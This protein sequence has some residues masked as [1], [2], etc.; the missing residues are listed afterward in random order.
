MMAR[1]QEAPMQF[2]TDMAL[3]EYGGDKIRDAVRA[4]ACR[5]GLK[6]IPNFGAEVSRDENRMGFRVS[7]YADSAGWTGVGEPARG[8][9]FMESVPN[10]FR[11]T[12]SGLW[13]VMW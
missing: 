12:L 1:N 10:L 8:D 2:V 4:E 11:T 6:S 5:T 3:V 9:L 13:K 7:L